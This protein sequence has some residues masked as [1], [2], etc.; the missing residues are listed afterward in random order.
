[1]LFRTEVLEGHRVALAGIYTATTDPQADPPFYVVLASVLRL[2]EGE[3]EHSR[4]G[5]VS[6]LLQTLAGRRC[7]EQKMCIVTICGGV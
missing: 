5:N 2:R 7:F 6:T 3:S 4:S 1:M